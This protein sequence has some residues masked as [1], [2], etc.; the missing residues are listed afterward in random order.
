MICSKR[1]TAVTTPMAPTA[2]DSAGSAGGD[3][4]CS[5]SP[6]ESQRRRGEELLY[7]SRGTTGQVSVRKLPG[8]D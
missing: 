4:V 7:R 2:S 3:P 5:A 8:C 6:A 1:Q